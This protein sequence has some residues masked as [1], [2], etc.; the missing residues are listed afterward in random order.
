MVKA[1]ADEYDVV[2][3]AHAPRLAVYHRS[4]SGQRTTADN[5]DVSIAS[6]EPV[7]GLQVNAKYMYRLVPLTFTAS[8]FY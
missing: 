7:S 5:E 1:T 8:H 2:N 4:S 3:A 6:V